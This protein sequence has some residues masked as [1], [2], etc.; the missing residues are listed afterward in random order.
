M[1]TYIIYALETRESIFVQCHFH[2][3]CTV[4]F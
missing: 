2:Y 3:N 4:F 1:Q